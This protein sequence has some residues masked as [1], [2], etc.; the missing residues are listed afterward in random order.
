MRLCLGSVRR[1]KT[2]RVAASV[3]KLP[4]ADRR[5][6]IRVALPGERRARSNIEYQGDMIEASEEVS[7]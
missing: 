6:G 4:Y 3:A 1:R 5:A 2:V 7:A